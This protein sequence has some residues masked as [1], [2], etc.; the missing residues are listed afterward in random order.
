MTDRT[1]DLMP[2][3]GF[4]GGP[5]HVVKRIDEEVRSPGYRD[6]LTDMVEHGDSLSNPQAAKIYD[7][8][9]EKGAGPFRQLLIGPHAQYRM[10]LRGVTVPEVRLALKS[11]GKQ[12]SDWKSQGDFR[13]KRIAEQLAHQEA[14]N[15]SDPKLKLTIVFRQDGR[16]ACKLITAYWTGQPDPPPP[17]KCLIGYTVGPGLNTFVTEINPS[18]VHNPNHDYPLPSIPWTRTKDTGKPSYTGVPSEQSESPSGRT[19]TDMSR[20]PGEEGKPHNDP[21]AR[22]AP[23]RRQEVQ[24]G[25]SGPPFPGV[26]R[27]R[28]QKGP[29]KLYYQKRYRRKKTE[30]KRRM[31]IWYQKNKNKARFKLDKKRRRE[32]P[33]KFER[34]PGGGY[35]RNKDRAKD[36]R[37]KQAS[38]GL[39]FWSPDDD[40]AGTVL[41]FDPTSYLIYF[42]LEDG[43]EDTCPLEEFLSDFAV[44]DAENGADDLLFDL[45]EQSFEGKVAYQVRQRPQRRQRRNRGKD[46][47][48]SRKNYRKNKNKYK[49]RARRRYKKNKNKPAFKKQQKIRRKHPERF[50]RRNAEVLTAPEIA[51]VIGPRFDLGY[52]RNVS[53]MTGMVTFQRNY[54]TDVKYESLP[55]HIFLNSVVFLSEEDIEAMFELVD[56]EAGEE[57]YKGMDVESVRATAEQEGVNCDS[58]EFRAECVALVGTPSLDEMTSEQLELVDQ[59]VVSRMVFDDPEDQ[60]RTPAPD[61]L[62]HLLIDPSDTDYIFG[63]VNHVESS[64]VASAWVRRQ[65]SFFYEKQEPQDPD[66]WYDRGTGRKKTKEEMEKDNKPSFSMLPTQNSTINEPGASKV[67]PWNSGTMNKQGGLVSQYQALLQK[68]LKTPLW[69]Q[70]AAQMKGAGDIVRWF[71]QQGAKAFSLDDWNALQR[72][73][74]GFPPAL[75]MRSA[76]LISDIEAKCEPALFEKAKGLTPRLARVD[77]KNGVWLFNVKSSSGKK[78]Y[79]VRVKAIRHGNVKDMNK[80]H[81]KLSCSCPYWRWQGPEFHAKQDIFQYGKFQGTA[82]PPDIR[83]PKRVH[84]A[85]KHMLSAL[86]LVKGWKLRGGMDK[87]GSR[88]LA[89]ILDQAVI[90]GVDGT[91]LSFP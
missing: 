62:D 35:V 40:M 15:W 78:S 84:A 25:M 69:R 28:D 88:Y 26:N 76:A 24:G 23:K 56:V 67:I 21:P 30:M 54:P 10:D 79:R 59:A 8:E 53:P 64:K 2:P 36:W 14:I 22:T 86:Q 1:A 73:I 45:V 50:K 61:A 43:T 39:T 31:K 46:R 44:F 37:A 57:A 81:V 82:S 63:V 38:E 9:R 90:H 74:T 7:L 89:D 71:R 60:D 70:Y 80:L 16:L 41:G 87:R 91:V 75:S 3:L 66:N 52:V 58:D 6:R 32:R 17:G 55:A 27:Q 83:D 33:E 47:L 11:F 68:L 48:R 51:F 5:C 85:C 72:E 13:A 19:V 34:R 18:R 29:A 77:M 65:A 12:Y 49:L 4:P 20:T 42:M